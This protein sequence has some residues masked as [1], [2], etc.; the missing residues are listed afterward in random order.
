MG[1]FF[2]RN[3]KA[4]ET[5]PIADASSLEAD[6]IVSDTHAELGD[7]DLT[8]FWHDNRESL[9][10]HT[11]PPL[12][13]A[14]IAEAEKELGFRL[15]KS[16]VQ[17]MRL[18][19]GGLVNRCRFRVQFP[20]F[21]CPDTIYITDIMGIGRDAPYSLLGR[22]GSRFLVETR[23]HNKKI[24]VAVCNTTLPGR[25]LVFLDYRGVDASDEPR[26]T[27]ADAQEKQELLL[28]KNFSEFIRG[29]EVNT[30]ER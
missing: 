16:Y 3:K 5:A 18:H 1:L 28:A 11:C 15:P 30:V 4:G 14:M 22:F 20:K 9:L 8:G 29:L 13:D 7:V 17:L 24:G 25:A 12:D 10:R 27:W 19:N 2:R 6:V 21:G 26:V 23:G